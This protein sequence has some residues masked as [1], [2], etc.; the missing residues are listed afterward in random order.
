VDAALK[1]S[2]LL[3]L[4]IAQ[5]D[6]DK[7][8]ARVFAR[9]GQSAG[10]PTLASRVDPALRADLAR[11][12]RQHGLAEAR[13][14]GLE[15]WAAALVLAQALQQD[16]DSGNGI[17]RAL[18]AAEPDKPRAELEGAERQLAIFDALPEREQRDLLGAVVRDGSAAGDEARIAEAWR[19]GNIAAIAALTHQ[20]LLADPELREALYTGRNRAWLSRLEALLRAGRHPFVAVGAAHLA[21]DDGLPALLAARGWRVAR[22]D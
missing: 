18:I 11:L 2:D 1:Q 15:T 3:V 16:A 6:N 4:E 8:T 9:L 5:L 22:V 17:D 19:S 14:S 13:F 12:M 21:G 20:G 10:Q 7:Q